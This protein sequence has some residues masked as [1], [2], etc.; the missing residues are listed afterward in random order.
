MLPDGSLQVSF[1]AIRWQALRATEGWAALQHHALL[2]GTL[3]VPE[4]AHDKHLLVELVQGSYFTIL[5]RYFPAASI[6]VE[7]GEYDVWVAGDYEGLSLEPVLP[8]A[9]LAPSQTRIIPVRI[10]QTRSRHPIPR[11]SIY[12]SR[13]DATYF[14]PDPVYATA[15]SSDGSYDDD[16]N[17]GSTLLT[18]QFT[19]PI[20]AAQDTSSHILV[21]GHHAHRLLRYSSAS[22]SLELQHPPLLALHGAG[23]DIFSSTFWMDALPKLHNQWSSCPAVAHHGRG[24]DWHGPSALDVWRSVDALGTIL[25][26]RG[27]RADEGLK[28]VLAGHSN[29]GQGAWYLATRF[30]DRVAGVIAA[31]AYMKSQAYVAW[32]MS[33]G[34]HFADPALNGVLD[35]SLA[36]DDND[37]FLSNLV[38]TPV[39]AIHGGA[40]ENV[41][42]WHTRE[43]VS[44]LKTLNPSA[45]VTYREDPGQPH[46]YDDV[47][48]N[49]PVRRFIAGL[50]AK[51]PRAS[52]RFTLT[53]VNP[54]ESGTLHGWA[55]DDLVTPGRLARLDVFRYGPKRADVRATNVLEFSLDSDDYRR[56]QNLTV[57]GQH[58]EWHHSAAHDSTRVHVSYDPSERIWRT[59]QLNEDP[60]SPPH[61]RV[62]SILST[63]DGPI[64]LRVPYSAYH[65]DQSAELNLALRIARDL[66]TYHKLDAEI[67]HDLGHDHGN[68]VVI[69]TAQ[70][71]DDGFVKFLQGATRNIYKLSGEEDAAICFPDESGKRF[72][73][74]GSGTG[75][76]SLHPNLSRDP[77]AAMIMYASDAAGLER[78]GRLFPIRTGVKVP[79]W[80]I[81]GPKMDELSTGGILGAG[82]FGHDWTWNEAM[83]VLTM[84]QPMRYLQDGN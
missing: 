44:T 14:Q 17:K 46:W 67:V 42:V 49:E 81:V 54:R 58:V 37:L 84:P 57:N 16:D 19:V 70:T 65:D 15:E 53:V 11:R 38:D 68:V 29:G 59:G 43:L 39:Y 80:M 34:A 82:F 3:T 55:I 72:C 25:R 41:P 61:S 12:R 4:N 76:I 9:M 63:T 45:N 6:A 78:L 32:T 50:L 62:Q 8:D 33:R 77:S 24:L 26:A 18:L 64:K 21:F 13:C 71:V 35:A 60:Y 2:H 79:G 73:V 5:P 47:L 22:G 56:L 66:D 75:L 28:V 40:D 10:T 23:V 48:D 74:E 30:P 69:Q 83:S 52:H 36:P 31:A 51:L 1:P 7:P 27:I 20:A